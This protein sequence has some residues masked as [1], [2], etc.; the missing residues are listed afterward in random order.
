MSAINYV[1]RA[2]IEQKPQLVR[3]LTKAYGRTALCLSGGAS[4]G[5]YHLGPAARRC[6]SV[7]CALPST[8]LARP[9][10][11]SVPLPRARSTGVVKALV[12][13]GVL[14]Q[15]ISGTSAGSL[16]ASFVCCRTD[17]ELKKELNPDV[18]YR[19]SANDEGF[20]ATF[21]RFL[22]EGVLFD[23]DRWA[24]KTQ[25]NVT[26]GHTTFLE[27][28]QRTGRILNICVA[29]DERFAPPLC[30][31]YKTTPNVVIWSAILAS[32][33]V[34]GILHAVE[35]RQKRP[36]GTLEPFQAV[37][38]RWRDGVLRADIPLT[39]TWLAG[40]R[41]RCRT[42]VPTRRSLLVVCAHEGDQ[43]CTSCLAS[44]T[45]WCRRSTRTSCPSSSRTAAR[46]ARRPCTAAATAGAR[47]DRVA[48]AR[49]DC[50]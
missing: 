39:R 6:H 27:A 14:P 33:A 35:L 2:E 16:V 5:Y 20:V 34:P 21:S 1:A 48:V 38:R 3:K 43:R 18:F 31:N 41:E 42:G 28:Y 22:R 50:A 9:V 26:L 25:R 37:G 24:E 47:L 23:T 45:R 12:E 8:F 29:S 30:L 32:A 7:A 4:F 10:R 11:R 13:R 19:F 15:V 40:Q 17:E 49:R 44:T 46:A 36:D